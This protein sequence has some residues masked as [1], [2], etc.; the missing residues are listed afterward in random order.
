ME[1]HRILAI[2]FFQIFN[3]TEARLHCLR[4]DPLTYSEEPE[5]PSYVYERWLDE[6]DLEKQKADIANLLIDCPEMRAHYTQMVGEKLNRSTV[7]WT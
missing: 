6:N 1:F 5:G 3:R 4:V 7:A 2:I